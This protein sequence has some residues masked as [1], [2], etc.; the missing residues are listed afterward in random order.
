MGSL[1]LDP[2]HK[3]AQSENRDPIELIDRL[4]NELNLMQAYDQKVSFC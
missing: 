4:E 2:I 3:W 1:G